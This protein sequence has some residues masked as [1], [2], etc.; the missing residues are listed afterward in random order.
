MIKLNFRIGINATCFDDRPSGAKNRF[1]GIYSE[2]FKKLSNCEFYVYEASN[3]SISKWF[4]NFKN[5][6]FIK[7]NIPSSGKIV[8]YIKSVIFWKLLKNEIDLDI[9]ETFHLPLFS[10]KVKINI[11][12]IH[13]L[14]PFLSKNFFY[15]YLF[16]FILNKSLKNANKII[17]VSNFINNELSKF[18]EKNKISTVYNGLL[19][20]N[21]NYSKTLHTLENYKI[22]EKFILSVGHFEKRKN[23]LNLIKAFDYNKYIKKNYNLVIV[24][25]DNGYKKKIIQTIKSNNLQKKIIL[26]SNLPD[27]QLRSL[28]QLSEMFVFPTYY[29]GFGIP[30][31][32]A[33]YFKKP[34]ATSNLKVLKE[35]S[36]NHVTYFEPNNIYDIS[37]KIEK[38]LKSKK[39][40][41]IQIKNYKN[42]LKKFN[43][44]TISEN[45]INIY[46][47]KLSK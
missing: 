4:N 2:V 31:I 38:L 5:V 12:T 27:T 7:T 14:R 34:I 9:F 11:L 23:Y 44:D 13:D 45:I 20:Y 21:N 40:Q 6:H 1:I 33:M 3:V 24:G 8:K 43:Y 29:E 35:I 10:N 46:S 26:I 47:N 25:N 30:V 42:I 18:T 17:T 28:Y 39:L 32:E 41:N 36:N 22:N 19:L 37:T 16:Y 15:K